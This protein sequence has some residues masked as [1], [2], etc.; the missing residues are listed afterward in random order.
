M[1]LPQSDDADDSRGGPGVPQLV[2]HLEKS[3]PAHLTMLDR[4]LRADGGRVFGVD[5][6][7][8]AAVNR[9][10]ALIRGFVDLVGTRNAF[11]AIPLLRLQLDNA[12]RLYACWLAPHHNEVLEA[13]LR[14]KSLR[15]VKARDGSPMSDGYL[16]EKLGERFPWVN[17]V[18]HQTSGFVH[19]SSIHMTSVVKQMEGGHAQFQIGEA[20]VEWDDAEATEALGGFIAATRTL[21]DVAGWWLATKARVGEE[22][23]PGQSAETPS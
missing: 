20:G 9:S 13:L 23:P 14:G 2:A 8:M 16:R 21:L 18:Y 4:I 6:V 22:R 19:L 17:D 3:L 10:M 12:M 1:V 7:A 15:K 5:L 11:C